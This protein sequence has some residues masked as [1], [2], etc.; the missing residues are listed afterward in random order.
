MK[1]A[2]SIILLIFNFAICFVLSQN[3]NQKPIVILISLD[4]FR[5]DYLN[6]GL[7]P[8]L[9]SIAEEGVKAISLKPQFPSMT[10]PNHYS[11]ITGLIPEKH[12]IIANSFQNPYNKNIFSLKQPAVSQA[13]WY[14]GEAF[15]ETAKRNGIRTASYF[16]PGSEMNIDFRR[17]D[18]YEKY[19]HNRPY[20][21]RVKGVL[22]W[23][24][25]PD[26]LR[27][28]FITLYFDETDSKGHRYGTNSPELKRGIERV[29]KMISMLDSSISSLGLSGIVNMIILSDHGMMDMS[30]DKVISVMELLENDTSVSFINHSSITFIQPDKDKIL[31]YYDM[32]KKREK[33]F[34][35]YLK[36]DIPD[37]YKYKNHPFISDIVL[38]AEPGWQ[39][40]KNLDW[41]STYI[42]TH[43][44]D[45]SIMEMHGIFLAKGPAF[46]MNYNTGT[47]NNIDI[48]PLLCRIFDIE[49][50]GN[51]DGDILN[52]IQV[53][54]E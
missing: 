10:F 54:K 6:R 33:G 14:Q 15:W 52:I 34:K 28:R 49:P 30:P 17:P 41:D 35:V 45:N 11:I 43:G 50:A 53:L 39:I 48:Y 12:G 8:E 1:R 32:I 25:L 20:E 42:A 26:S 2:A 3:D 37:R 9:S 36:K 23:L 22:D 13:V 27:P 44:Y 31:K 47:L 5:W 21:T 18:Y 4:G 38:I 51:I 24:S 40:R 46:K 16:W 19:E 29:D 7:S